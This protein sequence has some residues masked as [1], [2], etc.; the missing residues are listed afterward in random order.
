MYSVCSCAFSVVRKRKRKQRKKIYENRCKED[1][2]FSL[3]A[4][5]L[6]LALLLPLS[7]FLSLLV[8]LSV[9]SKR[10]LLSPRLLSSSPLLSHLPADFQITCFSLIVTLLFFGGFLKTFILVDKLSYRSNS[11]L[12]ILV[13]MVNKRVKTLETVSEKQSVET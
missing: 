9:S 10:F 2:S 3:P 13:Y 12:Q 11:H 4:V 7:P 6:L 8:F 5:F 1:C